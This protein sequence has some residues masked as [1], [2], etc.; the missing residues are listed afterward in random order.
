MR[1]LRGSLA[2][3]GRNRFTYE[4]D[5]CFATAHVDKPVT[6]LLR[7]IASYMTDTPGESEVPKCKS[8]KEPMTMKSAGYLSEGQ[9]I[10]RGEKPFSLEDD[11]SE[12]EMESM[13][14]MSDK[15][16]APESP[17]STRIPCY[18][19]PLSASF[20]IDSPSMSSSWSPPSTKE[21]DGK[22]RRIDF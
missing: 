2:I 22:R 20:S 8:C 12:S 9:I 3:V 10:L 6:A 21:P 13:V 19:T 17:A 15:C 14:S 1:A 7:D 4:C 5:K 18:D 11:S 16:E